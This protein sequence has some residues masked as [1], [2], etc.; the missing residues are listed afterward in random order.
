ME[1]SI[2]SEK[3]II[4]IAINGQIDSTTAPTL[5]ETL[6]AVV[7]EGN[8]RLILDLTDVPY[9]SSAGLRVLSIICK[10]ARDAED[11]G[12][13]RLACL[14]KAVAHAFRISGFDQIFRIYDSVGAALAEFGTS[15]SSA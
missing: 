9:M 11:K 12:D 8:T 3:G 10:N 6:K 2:R 1:T 7:N 15:A 5:E 13:L 4:I 14:S